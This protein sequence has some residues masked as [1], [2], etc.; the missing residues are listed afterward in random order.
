MGSARIW[1]ILKAK[2]RYQHKN[3]YQIHLQNIND[4]TNATLGFISL[5][6]ARR[7]HQMH[8]ELSMCL[9]LEK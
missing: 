4:N 6:A 2:P 1:R 8:Q 9:A 7:A 5:H 3:F